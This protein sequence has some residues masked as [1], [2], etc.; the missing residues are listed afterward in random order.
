MKKRLPMTLSAIA[1]AGCL[2][3]CS[4]AEYTVTFDDNYSGQTLS[5]QTVQ[6]GKTVQEVQPP[7]RDGYTFLGWFQDAT[8]NT[9]WDTASSK[10]AGDTTLYAGWDRDT[11]DTI[12]E[13]AN[14]KDFST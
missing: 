4:T 12:T 5:T 9:P 13:S 6:S 8:L 3:G 2:F 11:G 10:V 7:A 1:L 14:D